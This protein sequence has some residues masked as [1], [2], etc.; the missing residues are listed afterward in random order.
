MVDQFQFEMGKKKTQDGGPR[1][2]KYAGCLGLYGNTAGDDR[3]RNFGSAGP[4]GL[5]LW[6]AACTVH[7][8]REEATRL[9]L[10]RPFSS[11][12]REGKKKKK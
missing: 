5:F 4:M 7:M 11:V 10:S 3:G 2:S 12:H 1:Q 6:A 8:G 9:L